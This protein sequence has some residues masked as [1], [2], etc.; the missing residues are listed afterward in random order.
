MMGFAMRSDSERRVSPFPL[1]HS[2]IRF[3]L[4]NLFFLRTFSL[5]GEKG[6]GLSSLSS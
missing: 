6:E 3:A 2:F 4:R 5:L 1:H